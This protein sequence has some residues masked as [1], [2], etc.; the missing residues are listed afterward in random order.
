MIR[1][2]ALAALLP[3]VA[4]ALP[5][6]GGEGAAPPACYL[7]VLASRGAVEVVAPAAGT[8]A[9]LRVAVGE[10]V[11]AGQELARIDSPSGRFGLAEEAARRDAAKSALAGAEVAVRQARRELARR[12]G[13]PELF[14]TEQIE[15][16]QFQLDVSLLELE[17][18]EAALAQAEAARARVAGEEAERRLRAPF[19]AT[20]GAIYA[21][22][23]A[24]VAGGRPILQLLANAGPLI[25][26][27]VPPGELAAF[28]A[29]API[30]AELKGG[31][32]KTASATSASATVESVAPS[33]DPGSQLIFVEA[34]GASADWEGVPLGA[35]LR[36]TAGGRPCGGRPLT[37]FAER[38]E[39]QPLSGAPR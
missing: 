34:G 29:G 23:G 30:T 3:A 20:V 6:A 11:A 37:I 10:R 17:G 35:V 21:S 28:P 31:G 9:G 24:A 14:S 19:D 36:V 18:R 1:R 38:P 25:R 12:Q 5:A 32:P 4:L 39:S 7:G 26:F 15:A 16:A 22:P 13:T 8:L 33:L 27:A 2:V